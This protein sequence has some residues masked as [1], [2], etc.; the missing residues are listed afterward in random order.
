MPVVPNHSSVR[1]FNLPFVETE[2]QEW[3]SEQLECLPGAPTFGVLFCTEG[4][5]PHARDI[6]EVVRIYAHVP[7]MI[8]CSGYGLIAGSKEIEGDAGF[9]VVLYHLPDTQV[10]ACHIPSDIL[11]AEDQGESIGRFLGHTAESANAWMLFATADSLGSES[12]LLDWDRGTGGKVTIGGFACGDPEA[13]ASVLFCDGDVYHDGAVALSIEGAVTI[14]PILSHG[15]RPVGNPWT[16]TQAEHNIIHK[17]GNRPILEVLRDTLEGMSRHEQEQARGNIFVGVVIDEY[18]ANFRPGDFLVRN[19]AAI[20]PKTGSVAIATPLRVG[21]N[22]QFQIRDGESAAADMERA[23]RNSIQEIGGHAIYGA[24][25]CDC[26]GRGSSLFGV[27]D[28]DV[29]AL[30]SALPDLDV[31]GVFCNGEFGSTNGNTSL[32]GYAASLG[33]FVAKE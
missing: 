13:E 31:G 15:C 28:H 5:L 8:G 21:Q 10:S 18:K 17:I 25:L 2:L 22:L 14:A 4:A 33:L 32:H 12:W 27:P 6:L 7:V 3:A 24:C 1:H 9:C 19:L 23:L 20:D 29:S 26:V 11:L 30:R 16:V